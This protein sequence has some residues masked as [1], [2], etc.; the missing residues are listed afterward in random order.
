MLGAHSAALNAVE[1]R[2]GAVNDVVKLHLAGTE[3][4]LALRCRRVA[5][6]RV[7]DSRLAKDALCAHL[8]AIGREGPIAAG[9]IDDFLALAAGEDLDFEFSSHIH[10]FRH[11]RDTRAPGPWSLSDWLDGELLLS[12]PTPD[13]FQRLGARLAAL[14]QIRFDVFAPDFSQPSKSRIWRDWYGDLLRFFA[15]DLLQDPGFAALGQRLF[16]LGPPPEPRAYVLTHGDLHPA[17][18][19][20]TAQDVRLI[21]WDEAQIGPPEL[22]FALLR[23]RTIA[24]A[25]GRLIAARDL[26]DAFVA[27]YFQAGG[28][29]DETLLSYAQLLYLVRQ[30]KIRRIGG[31]EDLAVYGILSEID[32]VLLTLRQ[33]TRHRSSCV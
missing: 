24:D 32:G 19:L 13:R 29:L 31:A 20:I 30:L 7:P 10:M 18:V 6:P 14:H 9:R 25:T 5:F 28:S 17:N 27:G 2:A 21:D 12:S 33:S 11:G 23:Y 1:V 8:S 15:H 22:D 26:F 4:F 3:Q 16:A